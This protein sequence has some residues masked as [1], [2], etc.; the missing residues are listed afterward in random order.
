[1]QNEFMESA[2]IE[3]KKTNTD[4]PVGAVIVKND[5]IIT[6]AH[7]EKELNKDISAHAEIIAI[8]NASKILGDWRLSDCEMYVT[9]EPCPMCAWAIIQ[10]RF[11]SVYFGSYDNQYG[12]LGS[13]INLLNLSN[14]K[15]DV[16]GGIIEE[17]CDMLLNN[18]FNKVRNDN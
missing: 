7:N 8:K 14:N 11:K 3:A 1:M 4:I 18:F 12:A 13:K 16:K 10:S 6:K 5:K 2:I 9:L 17:K 15:I